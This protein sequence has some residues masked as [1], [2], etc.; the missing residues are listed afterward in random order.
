MILHMPT[1]G[2]ELDPK[3]EWLKIS[4]SSRL[5][6]DPLQSREADKRRLIHDERMYVL[7]NS[8]SLCPSVMSILYVH[9]NL[10]LLNKLYILFKAYHTG[11]KQQTS[12]ELLV[13]LFSKISSCRFSCRFCYFA[14]KCRKTR[15]FVC[16][17]QCSQTSQVLSLKVSN[18]LVSEPIGLWVPRRMVLLWFCC[19]IR[20]HVSLFQIKRN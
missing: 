19:R 7:S 20:L 16:N 4:T 5:F 12:C 15:P 6:Q 14:R 10:I 2:R 8:H 17:V 11:I 3:Y 9:G 13:T 18:C 1:R